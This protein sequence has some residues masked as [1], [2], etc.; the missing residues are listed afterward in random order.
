MEKWRRIWPDVALGDP[1]EPSIQQPES[2][3]GSIHSLAINPGSQKLTRGNQKPVRRG[4]ETSGTKPHQI[5][6]SILHRH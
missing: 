5:R 1:C 6:Y 3:Q 4:N 2:V